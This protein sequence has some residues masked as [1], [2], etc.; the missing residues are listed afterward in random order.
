MGGLAATRVGPPAASLRA[1][2][3]WTMGPG[4]GELRREEEPPE[5]E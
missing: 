4:R 3:G 2:E 1:V 5:S